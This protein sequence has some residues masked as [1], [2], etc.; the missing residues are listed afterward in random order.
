MA[1]RSRTRSVAP[2]LVV[3]ALAWPG[4]R[5]LGDPTCIINHDFVCPLTGANDFEVFYTST[6]G[7][8]NVTSIWDGISDQPQ[9][10]TKS[11]PPGNT[12]V[13]PAHGAFS[14]VSGNT[15][16]FM[17]NPIS[18]IQISG[19]GTTSVAV[20]FSGTTF[21]ANDW[22][23]VGIFG[24]GNARITDSFWT[25]NGVP[26]FSNDGH[27]PGVAF[28]GT[29]TSWLIVRVTIYDA[30][31]NVIGHE[32]AEE[33]ATADSLT[34]SGVPLFVSTATMLSSTQIPLDQLNENLGGFGPESPITPL[35]SL[36]EPS[37]LAL[38]GAG[39]LGLA[40]ARARSRRATAL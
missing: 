19:N 3:L 7:P 5:A 28:T 34:G 14:Q 17:G 27:M 26:V 24:T 33:Q 23:H 31:N 29:S 12:A 18:A 9:A 32:W 36:P 30:L 38:A 8:L 16:T 4:E 13:P 6:G 11:F 39:L 2:L 35:P 22:T 37:S 21:N 10:N 20:T 40:L 15:V 1:P 25:I